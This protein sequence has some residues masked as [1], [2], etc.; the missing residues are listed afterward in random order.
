MPA[1]QAKTKPKSLTNR[2][3]RPGDRNSWLNRR[4]VPTTI[5]VFGIRHTGGGTHQSKTMMLAELEELL[6]IRQHTPEN[7]RHAAIVDNVL[8]K[9]TANTRALTYRHLSAL[10][11]LA[12]QPPV[13]RVFLRLWQMCPDARRQLALMVALARD[14]LLRDAAQVVIDGAVGET[15]QRPLF[16]TLLAKKHPHRFSDS[17]LRSL[18]QNCASTFTQSGHL[19]GAVRKRRQRLAAKPEVVAFATLLASVAGFGGPAMLD[20]PWI[21]ILDLTPE[22]ALDQLR[23]AEGLGLARVRS[24]G[25]I[26]EISTHK[27]I[28]TTLRIPE[29]ELA[30]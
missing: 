13:T 28:A 12:Q 20:T 30:R 14:P 16:E 15:L 23:R 3:A 29:I 1:R 24:A 25:D 9:S 27:Q 11:G 5:D 6:A 4:A 8:G 21:R 22:Q 18:A 10:Y 19:V 17:M 2:A 26:T 7:L